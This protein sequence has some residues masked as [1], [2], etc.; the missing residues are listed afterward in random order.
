MIPLT[1]NSSTT[2]Q[3]LTLTL[4]GVATTTYPTATVYS[5]IVPPQSKPDF[6]EYRRAPEFTLLTV[7]TKTTIS[8]APPSGSVKMISNVCIPNPDT[9]SMT[10][11]VAIDDNGTS[12]IQCKVTLLTLEALYYE[13]GRGWYAVDAN[14][15]TKQVTGSLFS[16]ITVTGLT[17]SLPVFTDANK[18]LVSNTMTGT[19]SVVMSTS[20][21]LV[22]PTL[23]VAS[24]TSI[25]FGQTALNY[26][27]EGTWTP[28]DSSGASLTFSVALGR[29]TRIGDVPVVSAQVNYPATANGSAAVIGGFPF[30]V[31]AGAAQ[32]GVLSYSTSGTAVK[33]A[34]TASTTTGGFYTAAGAAVTNL[35]MSG[36]T[37]FFQSV[38]YV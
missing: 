18:A 7:A 8:A 38:Y 5:Y 37:N 24:A 21:T 30:T 13:D 35:Q 4:A 32:Q 14:G 10:M 1:N 29:Y 34:G 19:G 25:N 23:G 22:T 12:R 3:L 20:A 2:T 27:G 31:S 11:T 26:Y 28:I 15:N 9:V 16:S 6:S 33:F 36:T 17:A